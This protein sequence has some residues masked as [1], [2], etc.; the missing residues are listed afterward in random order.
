MSYVEKKCKY[1][2]KGKEKIM[3]N[4]YLKKIIFSSG[5]LLFM[6]TLVLLC[7]GNVMA[8]DKNVDEE[9]IM[10]ACEKALTVI[11][12][13]NQE[14][15][16]VKI[17][18]VYNVVNTEGELE[19]YSLGYFVGNKPYGYAIYDI[20]DLSVREFMFCPDVENL[21]KELENKAEESAKV[22]EDKLIEGVVYEGGIDYCAFDKDGNKVKY[23]E[24]E[25]GASDEKIDKDELEKI[26][27]FVYS[28]YTESGY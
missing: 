24:D 8:S 19:G 16:E 12:P 21:Y 10:N 11:Q 3:K 6:L 18:D 2:M 5:K 4:N 27:D 15:L 23:A 17:G 9:Q 7:S 13:M 20:E 25:K 14:N 22:D 26:E 28:N 1:Y